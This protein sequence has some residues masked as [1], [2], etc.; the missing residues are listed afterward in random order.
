MGEMNNRTMSFVLIGGI[1]MAAPVHAA[2]KAGDKAPNVSAPLSDG[3]TFQLSEWLNRAPIVLYFYPKDD[4]PGC[5]KEACALRDEFAAFR[6]LKATVVGC[7]YDSI[8]SHKKFIEKYK[9]PFPL[10]SDKDKTVA[11][12]FGVGGMFFAS[13]ATFIIGPDGTILYAN[14]SVDPATHSRE[15]Q[16]ALAKISAGK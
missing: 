2:L 3:T 13:R 9:L 16:E 10:I 12:A 11:K 14:P 7:S 15:I 8:E 1:L 6:H 4:T 5:T